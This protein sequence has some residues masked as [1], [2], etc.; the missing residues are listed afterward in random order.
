MRFR[1][2]P[3]EIEAQQ[4]DG[5]GAS[6]AAI[7]FW[8]GSSPAALVAAEAGQR[9]AYVDGSGAL[10]IRIGSSTSWSGSCASRPWRADILTI[11][12]DRNPPLQVGVPPLSV[13]TDRVR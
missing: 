11:Q 6:A 5:S 10:F 12:L 13:P 9:L 7:L 2:K 8:I 3:V 1:K 4:F